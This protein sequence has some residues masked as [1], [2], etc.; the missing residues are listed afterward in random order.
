VETV[1]PCICRVI[2]EPHY[3][4]ELAALRCRGL[5]VLAGEIVF[6]DR[7]AD[8]LEHG[9]RLALG[10][11]GFAARSGNAAALQSCLDDMRL[12][13]L[14]NR[15]EEQPLP[16]LLC[17]QAAD[18]IVLVQPARDQDNGTR[19]LVVQSTAEGVVVPFGILIG[20]DHTSRAP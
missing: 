16:R 19:P 4:D 17:Q 6:A 18:Q 8:L 11:Q 3:L 2:P 14:G 7:A 1:R 12:V 10:M 13:V 9:Q 15:R 5:A 20:A